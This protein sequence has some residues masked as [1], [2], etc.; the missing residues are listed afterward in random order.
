MRSCAKSRSTALV[1]LKGQ[2]EAFFYMD[3][4]NTN[5]LCSNA[6]DASVPF[7]SASPT[8]VQ[9]YWVRD[10]DDPVHSIP[11]DF[12]HESY[13]HLRS[14]ALQQ[15]LNAPSGT[16]PHDMDVLYQF[17]SHFLIRNFNTSMYNEFRHYATEDATHRKT[18]VGLSALIKFYGESLL[19]STSLIRGCVARDYVDLVKAENSHCRPA[20]QQLRSAFRSGNTDPD[21]RN[22][23]CRLLDRDWLA[24][25]DS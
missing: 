25:M 11:S 23:I 10:H 12:G 21:S 20:F 8:P 7:R 13:Y 3:R 5:H 6:S 14:K 15:R 22:C 2:T 1:P 19:S 16:I 17:W 24:S 18:H 9:V 4:L